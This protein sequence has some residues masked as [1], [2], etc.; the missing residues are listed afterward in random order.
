MDNTPTN[1]SFPR[2]SWGRMGLNPRSNKLSTF[3]R[4]EFN[5]TSSQSCW[6][7]IGPK[8]LKS[9]EWQIGCK[10]MQVYM[11]GESSKISN[12]EYC[13]ILQGLLNIGMSQEIQQNHSTRCSFFMKVLPLLITPVNP[14]FPSL[15]SSPCRDES[16]DKHLKLD[17]QSPCAGLWGGGYVRQ[18][19]RGD[20]GSLGSPRSSLNDLG[21]HIL[22]TPAMCNDVAE[23]F[24]TCTIGRHEDWTKTSDKQCKP[25]TYN[26]LDPCDEADKIPICCKAMDQ[27]WL[28][29]PEH[30]WTQNM[31]FVQRDWKQ[32]K[33]PNRLTSPI[34]WKP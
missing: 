1:W 15:N 5:M 9:K 34:D 28:A 23:L 32:K 19:L 8:V 26:W 20:W 18:N 33:H 25:E 24:D 16:A 4:R 31:N 7:S 10:S 12:V 29:A 2:S 27:T 21:V 30:Q 17:P 3:P 22:V 6:K 11:I 13:W 14:P